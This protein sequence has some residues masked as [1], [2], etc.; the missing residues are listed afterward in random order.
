MMMNQPVEHGSLKDT[1]S[2]DKRH[3][4]QSKAPAGSRLSRRWPRC[5]T[6]DDNYRA[7]PLFT[8]RC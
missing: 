3:A 7:P 4:E 5:M 6:L 1:M 8:W 2:E